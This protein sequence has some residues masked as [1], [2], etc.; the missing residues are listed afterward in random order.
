[1]DDVVAD[2]LLSNEPMRR[3]YGPMLEAFAAEGGDA[4]SLAHMMLV[5]PEYIDAAFT[6]MRS[7]STATSTGTCP[8][9]SASRE[10]DLDRLRSRL[11]T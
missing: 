5:R 1:M 7:Q 8:P 10:T 3:A 4:E 6:L 2:Y 11:L 9:G